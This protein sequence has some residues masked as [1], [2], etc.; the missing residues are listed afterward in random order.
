MT[1]SVYGPG[2]NLDD[3]LDRLHA[4]G[5]PAPEWWRVPG[6]D[7]IQLS[8]DLPD[9]PYCVESPTL[10]EAAKHMIVLALT[11][12]DQETADAKATV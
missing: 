5:A 3:L 1:P 10:D 2:P 8:V 6:V 12:G 4:M 7:R 9:G 11:S